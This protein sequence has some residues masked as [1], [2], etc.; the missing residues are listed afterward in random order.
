MTRKVHSEPNYTLLQN[1]KEMAR[2]EKEITQF[3]PK[4][5]VTVEGLSEIASG[6]IT[7]WYPKR[8]FFSVKWS[9]IPKNFERQTESKSGLRAFFKAHLFSTQVMFKSTTLRRLSEEET[10]DGSV[11]YHYRIP[12][13]IYQQQSRGALRVPLTSGA[14]TLCTPQGDFELLDLSVSGAKL[15]RIPKVEPEIGKEL[16]TVEL[17]FG[18]KKISSSDFHV[19]FTRVASDWCA[20]TFSKISDFERTQ[21]KQFLI[22]A[23]RIYY[24]EELRTRS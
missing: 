12:E 3:Q 2:I 15:K 22:E 13:Q 7:E 9:K 11:V 20:V 6:R 16:K 21:I 14:A 17:Y 1:P 5:E 10:Q 4:T 8:K 23:L 19:K 18:K 24:E